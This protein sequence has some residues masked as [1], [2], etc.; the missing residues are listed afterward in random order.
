MPLLARATQTIATMIARALLL[1]KTGNL[2][3]ETYYTL[4]ICV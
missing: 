1:L 3:I 2:I 4:F